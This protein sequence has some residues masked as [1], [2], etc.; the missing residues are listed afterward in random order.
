MKEQMIERKVMERKKGGIVI[1][2][3]A[4]KKSIEAK[5]GQSVEIGQPKRR[6]EIEVDP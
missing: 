3:N 1:S 2:M 5:V 4:K 6:R